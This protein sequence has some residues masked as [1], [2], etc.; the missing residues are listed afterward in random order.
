[1]VWYSVYVGYMVL[2]RVF[3]FICSPFGACP[4]NVQNVVSAGDF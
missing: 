4:I 3:A 2:R 1:M